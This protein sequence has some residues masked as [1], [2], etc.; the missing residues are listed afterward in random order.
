MTA[1]ATALLATTTLTTISTKNY[2]PPAIPLTSYINTPASN[3]PTANNIMP[4]KTALPPN[5][6]QQP[7][8]PKSH[9]LWISTSIYLLSWVLLEVSSA[10]EEPSSAAS[11]STNLVNQ[12]PYKDNRLQM[13]DLILPNLTPLNG[14][15]QHLK[16]IRQR[17]VQFAWTM[18]C[19]LR[20]SVDIHTIRNV[21]RCGARGVRTVLFA[22]ASPSTP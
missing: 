11:E 3:A 17:I 21:F 13:P 9:H 16:W 6:H 22:R 18:G 5:Q 19:L 4:V 7:P 8:P 14:T 12:I 10:W 20:H 1:P 15:R 2:A